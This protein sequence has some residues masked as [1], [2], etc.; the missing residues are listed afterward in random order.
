[1][2][3]LLLLSPLTAAAVSMVRPEPIKVINLGANVQPMEIAP[4]K[5]NRGRGIA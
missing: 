5:I 4:I 2:K 1:M 3:V